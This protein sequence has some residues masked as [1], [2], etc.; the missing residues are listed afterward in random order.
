MYQNLQNDPSILIFSVSNLVIKF[1]LTTDKKVMFIN[2][3]RYHFLEV[4]FLTGICKLFRLLEVSPSLVRTLNLFG[5]SFKIYPLISW[6]R[7]K[8]LHFNQ[9]FYV[10]EG[11]VLVLCFPTLEGSKFSQGSH[12]VVSLRICNIQLF[13]SNILSFVIVEKLHIPLH[14]PGRLSASFPSYFLQ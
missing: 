12:L 10:N 14:D 8:R 9:Q 1:T 6:L 3:Q 13:W 2:Y 7:S 5:Q 4:N 11:F